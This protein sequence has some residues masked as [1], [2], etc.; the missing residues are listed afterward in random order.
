MFGFIRSEGISAESEWRAG[1]FWLK[2]WVR[3]GFFT[4]PKLPVVMLGVLWFGLGAGLDSI[5]SS[6][7]SFSV[8]STLN[9][10]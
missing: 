10:T 6:F 2:V 8:L 3:R 9:L 4:I 1:W 7:S 5:F